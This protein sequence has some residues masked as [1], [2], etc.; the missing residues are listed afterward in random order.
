MEVL[1][2]L[3]GSRRRLKLNPLSSKTIL[4]LALTELR[5]FDENAFIVCGNLDP[6]SDDKPRVGYLLQKWS[7]KWGAYVDVTSEDEVHDGDKLTVVPKPDKSIPVS[8]LTMP[9]NLVH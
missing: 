5:I 1:F 6:P 4:E 2:E 8:I 9:S 3:G 7:D